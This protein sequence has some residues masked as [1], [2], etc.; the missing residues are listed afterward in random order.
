MYGETGTAMR[1]D[2]AGLLRQ[3]RVQQRLGGPPE[4]REEAGLLIRQYRQTVLLWCSQ[5]MRAT[6]PLTFSNL[7]PAQ[8]N[9]FRAVGGG[10]NSATPAGEL[11]RA[12][13]LARQQSTALPATSEQV[14]TPT[15]HDVIERWRESARAASLAEHD[16]ANE[17]AERMTAG[18]AQVVVGDVA[19]ITQALVVLD[20]RYRNTPGWEQL[21]QS[22]RLGWASLAAAL[23]VNLRQP[24][25]TVDELGWRPKTKIIEGP[26]KE[27][28]LG[29]LQA[30]HNLVVRMKSFPN[31]ANLRYIIDSQ[32][33]LSRRLVPF[34]GRIDPRLAEVWSDRADTY[35]TLQ[36]QFR[37]IGGRLGKGGYAAAEGANT[38]SR[39]KALPTD[40][41]VEPRILGGFQLLFGK[42]DRRIADVIEDGIDRCAFLQRVTLPRV[43]EGSGGLV[44]PVR[45]RFMPVD[46]A[47]NP[48]LM[49]TIRGRLRSRQERAVPTPGP[50]RADLHAAL[51]HRPE[52][53]ASGL[54]L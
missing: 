19:A 18:Q 46:R 33:L 25:Y 10:G 14:T 29:V 45:E 51:I 2:L 3:H 26:V 16:T 36:Q 39:I 38:V 22:A 35:A 47:A 12:L 20:Q 52:P 6:S 24:D 23:D 41:V 44:A 43:V 7:A 42:L 5:A 50:T 17:V 28:I 48:E 21:A 15:G 1:Q 4:A 30:E 49:E 8:P 54:E 13:E 27:G 9:P 31:A 11:A 34:A 40:T 53:R 32:R 37:R